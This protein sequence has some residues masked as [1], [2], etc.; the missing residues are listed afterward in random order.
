MVTPV[1]GV[2]RAVEEGD[3][4]DGVFWDRDALEAAVDDETKG[5]T[6]DWTECTHGDDD[7]PI[8]EWDTSLVKDMSNLFGDSAVVQPE[9]SAHCEPKCSRVADFNADIS[10]WDTSAV[11][12]FAYMFQNA[13]SF[14][15][16]ISGWDVSSATS[17]SGM[18]A[19]AHAFN[20]PIGSWDVSWV[21]YF[22]HVFYGAHSFNQDLPWDVRQVTDMVGMFFN[23]RAFNGDITSWRPQVV[24]ELHETFH[25]AFA[26]DRDITSWELPDMYRRE[27]WDNGDQ[28]DIEGLNR[29]IFV[30]KWY[31]AN[32]FKNATAWLDKYERLP[33]LLYGYSEQLDE[34]FWTSD[35]YD[36]DY[37]YY[38]DYI[39][40]R[41]WRMYGPPSMWVV[42]AM[43]EEPPTTIIDALGDTVNINGTDVPTW[44][45]GFA[46]FTFALS[47]L[48][49]VYLAVKAL[50]C[51]QPKVVQYAAPAPAQ[52][53]YANRV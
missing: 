25:N 3:L 11:T 39:S 52:V 46:A 7:V 33:G 26:F 34:F 43:S 32:T 48:T 8:S 24:Y 29:G 20:Q 13:W 9:Q 16:D 31:I 2:P 38:G 27:S 12:N 5:C 42:K 47:I 22:W 45:V 41:D 40:A 4:D 36:Y 23:A 49:V 1:G 19:D 10:Q 37:D 28:D 17:M 53:V 6:G 30:N 21:R 51:A 35:D 44:I 14:N 15:Q 18:F 50:C